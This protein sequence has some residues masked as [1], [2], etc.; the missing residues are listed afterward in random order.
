MEGKLILLMFVK[1]QELVFIL[2]VGYEQ[3]TKYYFCVVRIIRFCYIN[4]TFLPLLLL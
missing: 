1:S 2:K 3:C 4:V